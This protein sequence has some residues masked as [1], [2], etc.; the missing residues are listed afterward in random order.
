MSSGYLLYS[1]VNTFNHVTTNTQMHR[2]GPSVGA[3]DGAA[4][5][6]ELTA[7]AENLVQSLEPTRWLTTSV[8]LQL[9][10]I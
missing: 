4:V 1:M 7:F 9:Y 3:G 6:R 10:D 5:K 8:T 2:S